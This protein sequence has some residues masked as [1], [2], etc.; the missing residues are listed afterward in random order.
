MSC[1]WNNSGVKYLEDNFNKLPLKIISKNL[2]MEYYCVLNKSR[3]LGLSGSNPNYVSDGWAKIKGYTKS[4]D[5]L[6]YNEVKIFLLK[7]YNNYFGRSGNRVLNKENPKIF[8]S[9]YHYTKELDKIDD[10]GSKSF[11]ARIMFIINHDCDINTITCEC[12]NNITFKQKHSPYKNYEYKFQPF[13][14]KCQPKYPSEKYFK[15]KYGEEWETHRDD[16][17]NKLSKLKTNSKEWFIKKYGDEWKKLYLE[18]YNKKMEELH[19]NKH[20][21]MKNKYSKISQELFNYVYEKIITKENVYYATKNGEFFINLKD[22]H[23]LKLN[24]HC[25]RPDF[26]VGNKIIEFNGDYWH[27]KTKEE[28]KL[29]YSIL[30]GLGYEVLVISENEYKKNKSIIIEKCVNFIN[31]K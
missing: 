18:Y 10:K 21:L 1:D 25:I 8:N 5:L 3:K 15:F 24:K 28:D 2:G 27:S 26:K 20:N 9:L 11:M 30:G 29:R 23:K 19:N 14:V 13:C 7:N 12:G 16:R 22:E 6:P 17:R 4:L 31:G